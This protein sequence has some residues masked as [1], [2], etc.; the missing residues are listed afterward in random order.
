M[1]AG[2]D[3]EVIKPSKR[4]TLHGL[5]RRGVTDTKGS[6]RRKPRAS[7]HQT[8]EMVAL[9]DHDVS[10]VKP[11]T[12]N[13]KEESGAPYRTYNQLIKRMGKATEETNS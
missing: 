10:V 1:R 9:Y 11:A 3:T 6:R 13:F 8:E 2:I 7:G 12:Q 4:F 5:K